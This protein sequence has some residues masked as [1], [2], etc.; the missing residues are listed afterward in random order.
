MP[1]VGTTIPEAEVGCLMPGVG[2]TKPEAEGGCL[3]PG[4]GTGGG[5]YDDLGPEQLASFRIEPPPL[6]LRRAIVWH[7]LR[8]GGAIPGTAAVTP[9]SR[10]S[11]EPQGVDG[12]GGGQL[13]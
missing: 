13:A 12:G 6:A 9:R 8:W 3:M 7:W 10:R 2:T 5:V 4:E 11:R 1:G